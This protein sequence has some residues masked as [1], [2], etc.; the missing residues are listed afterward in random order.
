[1]LYWNTD[2]PDA[3]HVN[4]FPAFMYVA[5]GY[6]NVSMYGLPCSEYPGLFKVSYNPL[7]SLE[8][9]LKACYHSGPEVDP[10]RRDVNPSSHTTET[11]SKFVQNHFKG[12]SKEPGIIEFCMYT[13]SV[14]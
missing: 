13:V 3:F 11:T 5:D 10:D 6:Y 8:R 1:M 2:N 12:L 14:S 4:N 7:Y 9:F